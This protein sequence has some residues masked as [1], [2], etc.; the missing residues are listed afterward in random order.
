MSDTFKPVQAS[1]TAVLN[2][3]DNGRMAVTT[4]TYSLYVDI[5]GIHVK[6]TDVLTGTYSNISGQVTPLFNKIYL[7]TD[8]DKLVYY[9]SSNNT[10]TKHEIGGGSG[11]TGITWSSVPATSSSN[12]AAGQVAYDNGYFY[13]CVATNTWKRTALST[14]S[15]PAESYSVSGTKLST[16]STDSVSG[17]KL[18][19]TNGRGTV[20]GTK[21]ILN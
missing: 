2:T 5:S 9:T 15:A 3:V 11:G 16:I 14:W 7:A 21:L 19:I 6:I 8:Q 1:E 12:G 20:S 13:V 17:T 4:D 10:V 18:I